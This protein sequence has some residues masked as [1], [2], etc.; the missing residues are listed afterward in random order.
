M[1]EMT[2]RERAIKAMNFE[3]TDR[4]PI[5]ANGLGSPK[6][7]QKLTNI[8]EEEYWADQPLAHFNAMR[9]L[10]MDFH[11]QN[12][13]PPREE[14]HRSWSLS[15]LERWREP[16]AVAE[17]LEHQTIEM[18][19]SWQRL[20]TGDEE[21]EKRIFAICDYQNQ[22]QKRMGNDLLWVFGMDF[23]GPSIIGFPYGRYGYEGFFLVCGLY[24]EV[25]GRYWKAASRLSSNLLSCF[26]FFSWLPYS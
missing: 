13:F 17:D 16:E 22:M 18:E 2:G 3:S 7:V 6:Y 9:I 4:L 24:P 19:E 15:Q 1:H 20:S 11:I 14:S 26:Y 10:G 23:H 8:S 25:L 5:M 21:R 12:W